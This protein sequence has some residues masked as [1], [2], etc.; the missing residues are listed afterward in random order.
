VTRV[1][2]TTRRQKETI[3]KEKELY[4]HIP[5]VLVNKI[6]RLAN[7]RHRDELRRFARDYKNRPF[8]NLTEEYE[9]VK[10]SISNLLDMFFPGNLIDIIE[11]ET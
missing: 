6:S 9:Y 4:H 1:L 7:V 5:T 11:R 8:K 10:R 2:G 3:E